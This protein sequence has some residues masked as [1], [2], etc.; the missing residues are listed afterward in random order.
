MS[1]EYRLVFEDAD[2]VQHVIDSLKSSDACIKA[3]AQGVCLK[4][5]ELQTQAEYDVRLTQDGDRSVWLEVNFRSVTLYNLM[6]R[7][8]GSGV[9]RCFEDGDLG[10]EVTLK[11][12]FRIK[13]NN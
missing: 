4:D 11:D 6:Q 5:R 12:A 13:A 3:Q 2:L 1:Y 8:L 10:D 9:V 7:A